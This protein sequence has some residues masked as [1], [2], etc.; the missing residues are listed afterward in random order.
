MS[1]NYVNYYANC[2]PHCSPCQPQQRCSCRSCSTPQCPPT[3]APICNPCVP[4]CPPQC[5]DTSVVHV[6]NTGANVVVS[7]IATIVPVST[8]L[9][10]VE[11]AIGGITND[12]TNNRFVVPV[13]GVY[14]I[15]YVIKL[16]TSAE[17]DEILPEFSV[18]RNGSGTT[19]SLIAH[20]NTL[21]MVASETTYATIS[22]TAY[23]TALDTIRLNVI[24]SSGTT[25]AGTLT[26]NI[27]RVTIAKL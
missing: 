16:M 11:T 20:Q 24:N 4:I 2:K 18:L 9:T 5:P 1:S 7:S 25:Q 19:T 3:Y 13:A 10:N 17:A 14:G 12:T 15:T 23:L 8:T 6:A 27:D 21:G 22:A 26:V